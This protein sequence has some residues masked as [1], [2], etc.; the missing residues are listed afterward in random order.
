MSTL[1][2]LTTS[3]IIHRKNPLHV[4]NFYTPQRLHKQTMQDRQDLIL[5]LAHLHNKIKNIKVPK[6][7]LG[8]PFRLTTLRKWVYNYEVA[9]K[10][11]FSVVRHGYKISNDDLEI[12][13]IV[14][15][16]LKFEVPEKIISTLKYVPP[17]LPND[18]VVSKVYLKFENVDFI[19]SKLHETGRL[20]LLA[21]VEWLFARE[22]SEINFYF[23]K[24]G[25]LQKRDTSTWPIA[26]I[27]TWPSWLRTDLFGSGIDIDSAYVQFLLQQI[28]QSYVGREGVMKLIFPDLLEMLDNKNVW[29]NTLCV[30]T[31]KLPPNEENLNFIKKICMGIANGSKISTSILTGTSEYSEIKNLIIEKLP[32][33]GIEHLNLI[34]DRLTTI[35]NQFLAAKKVICNA[36]LKLRASK[37]NQR[38]VFVNYFEWERL[39]RYKIWEAVDYHGL[40]IHDGIDGIPQPYLEGIDDIIRE[41]SLKLTTK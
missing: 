17:P 22:C 20:D 15:R 23:T 2:R 9:F 5:Y 10:Y 37:N 34:G 11:F 7:A 27:E 26:G 19:F 4:S 1:Y 13:F 40:M 39:A 38:Q 36:Q 35:S 33:T 24:A 3:E 18:G 25:K 12:S 6:G 8:F 31:F 14:P 28:K 21:P 29:R 16:K 32:Q 30:D 41:L